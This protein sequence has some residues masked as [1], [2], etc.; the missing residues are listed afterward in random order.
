MREGLFEWLVLPFGLSNAPSMFMRVMNQAI[1]PFI[2]C[3]V[4][5]YFD[6]ML[7]FSLSLADHLI[8]LREVLLVLKLDQLFGAAKK[9]E[10]GVDHVLFLGYIVSSQGLK[11]DPAKVSAIESWPVPRSITEVQSFH[12][13]ASFYRCFVPQF[14]SIMSPIID[15]MKATQFSWSSAADQ[16]FNAIK[17]K[18]TSAPVLILPNFNLAFELHCDASKSGIGAV[19]S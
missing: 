4:V 12:G 9:C 10:F 6:D 16:A 7:I 13:L 11:V 15:C 17:A 18:L 14:S 2:G 19:L 5:V 3:F 1:R 8:H